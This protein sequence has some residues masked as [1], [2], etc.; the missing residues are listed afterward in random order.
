MT[1]P[2]S[3]SAS[4]ETVPFAPAVAIASLSGEADAR[5]ASAV[6]EYI[7]AAFLGGISLDTASRA[8]ARDLVRRGRNEYLP[9]DPFSFIES[10]L[11]AIESVSVR[12]GFNL[13]SATV[14]PLERAAQICADRGAIAE[15]NAHCRQPEL[16][17]AGCGEAL[18]AEPERLQNYVATAAAT[19]ADVSV[20]LRTE[21]SDVDLKATARLIQNAGGSMIHVDAMDSEPMVGT[22]AEAT[23]IAVIANNGVRDRDTAYTYLEHGADAVSVG[24]PSNDP[25][26]MSR[27]AAAV[28]GYPDEQIQ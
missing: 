16:C 4:R 20:K 8:A 23:D 24:R 27:V 21:L 6:D 26:V 17:E 22:I 18:L 28:D 7:G 2:E 5:W 1:P 9:E 3:P 10:Q 25:E 13:R 11:D 12:P 14:Q 15:I 19:G